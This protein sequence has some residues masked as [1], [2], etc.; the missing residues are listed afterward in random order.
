MSDKNDQQTNDQLSIASAIAIGL[1]AMIGAGI[2]ALIGIAVELAGPYA[3]IS[4]IIA[5]ALAILTAYNMAK[6][7]VVIPNKGGKVAYI[8]HAFESPII[9]GGFSVLTIIGYIIVNSLYARAFSD[10]F[11]ALIDMQ[12][13]ELL[14]HF[15]ISG[16]IILFVFINFFGAR[17]VGKVGLATAIIQTAILLLFGL[18]GMLEVDVSNLQ[19]NEKSSVANII[20]VTGIIFM[21]YEGFGLVANT[22]SDIRKPRKN[23]PRALYISILIVMIVYTIVTIAV[24]GN[25]SIPAII[26]AKEY[27][28][29]EAASPI[30][31]SRG[32]ALMGVAAL[33][34]TAS[35]INSTIYG[36]VYMA[37]E[38]SKAEQL[39]KLIQKSLW[40]NSSGWALLI[41]GSCILITANLLDL[42][43]IAETG[44]LIF[45]LI[46]L[47]VNIA[48]F[49]MRKF[50]KSTSWIIILGIV[51]I[52]FGLITLIYFLQSERNL[53]FY[54][55]LILVILSFGFQF[56]YQQIGRNKKD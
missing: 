13:N 29:A 38:T 4:F 26:E 46:Y 23:L 35:A 20:L 21:S 15:L 12:N 3:F 14:S 10:Y 48:N 19:P 25:L 22:A 55:F 50:T 34:A 18:S 37:Q 7:A 44:S 24:I 16:I 53:S 9:T 36:P 52:V 27:V 43:T 5:G 31:G 17:L 1:G 6:L 56:F 28:L 8:N 54:I 39:P 30:F 2:F 33:F 32:F 51:A 47:V 45:L 41:Y 11:L 40:G 49:K 42:S